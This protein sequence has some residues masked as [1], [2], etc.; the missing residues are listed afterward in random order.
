MRQYGLSSS[1]GWAVYGCNDR[2]LKL[3]E[4]I[5]E[6]SEGLG[7]LRAL[8]FPVVGQAPLGEVDEVEA[9]AE[10]AAQAAE[11]H[12]LAVSAAVVLWALC[13]S[14]LTSGLSK[15]FSD[16][17]VDSR[18]WVKPSCFRTMMSLYL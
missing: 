2:L 5:R 12:R 7:H 1:N 4:S 17:F 14:V 13:T 3:N 6:V 9:A 10:D 15:L 18:M 8:P 11:Q 16:E